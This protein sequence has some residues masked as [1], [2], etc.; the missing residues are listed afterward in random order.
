MAENNGFYEVDGVLH[1]VK[2]KKVTST[3][4]GPNQGKEFLFVEFFLEKTSQSGEKSYTDVIKFTTTDK[5]KHKAL[6]AGVGAKIHLTFVLK[7]NF[8]KGKF[9]E[10]HKNELKCVQFEILQAGAAAPQNE[11][12]FGAQG[13]ES[14]D[15]PF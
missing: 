4:P 14:Q 11:D 1:S 12:P 5:T 7:G 3:K 15:L 8:F 2:E 6:E 13:E 10:S 9:G